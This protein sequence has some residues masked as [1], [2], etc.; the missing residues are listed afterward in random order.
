MLWFYAVLLGIVQG[1]TEFLP[2]SSTAHLILIEKFLKLPSETFGLSYD[3]ALHWGTLA[4][5]LFYFRKKLTRLVVGIFTGHAKIALLLIT[6]TIP[7]V[8][9]GVLF[10]SLIRSDI[11]SPKLIGVTLIFFS[12]VFLASEK[13]GKKIKNIKSISFLDSLIIGFFQSIAL[14]PGVSRSGITISAGMLLNF[15]RETAG[16]YAFLLSIPIILIASVKDISTYTIASLNYE[17]IQLFAIGIVTSAIVGFITIS[18]FLK[19]LKKYSLI[20]FIIYRII[21]ALLIFIL[22]S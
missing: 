17:Q 19:F 18:V 9:V 7:A 15:D 3:I 20:P 1:L 22:L 13:I 11:R 21:L 6:G 12:F 5:L 4:A 2:V 10:E 14:V 16:E 8:V